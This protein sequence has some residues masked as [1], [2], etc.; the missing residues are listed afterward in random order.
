[1]AINIDIIAKMAIN[2]N[3][4]SIKVRFI[5]KMKNEETKFR[6]E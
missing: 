3:C 4:N 2:L 1:M 5:Y 6:K